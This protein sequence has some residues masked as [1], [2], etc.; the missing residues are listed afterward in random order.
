MGQQ[1]KKGGNDNFKSI[2]DFELLIVTGNFDCCKRLCLIGVATS[3]TIR[4]YEQL[5]L[6]FA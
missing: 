1:I 4:T 3:V 5:A 6:Y 2:L